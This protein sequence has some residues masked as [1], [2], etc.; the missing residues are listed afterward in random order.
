LIGRH[1]SH[2]TITA[3]LGEGGMAEVYRAVDT[4]LERTVAL[5]V[6][7]EE[8]AS[9]PQRLARFQ[10]EAKTVAALNHPNIV[11]IFSV[12]EA[13]G[14]HFLTMELVAGKA[15][16]ELL[17]K[18]GFSLDRFLALAT[19][20]ADAVASAHAQGIVHRDLKPANVMVTDEGDRVKVL[21]FGLAKPDTAADG[22]DASQ[23]LT[24]TQTQEGLILGTPHYMSPEQARG[25]PVDSRSDIFSLG[26]MFFELATGRRP[27]QGAASLE[28]L[29]SLLKDPPPRLLEIRPELPRHLGRV[30][31]RC[32]E[33]APADRYKTARDVYNELRA[34]HEETRTGSRIQPG[35]LAAKESRNALFGRDAERSRLNRMLDAATNGAGGLV[36]IG[37]EP[38]VGKTR[39]AVETLEDARERGLLVLTGHGYQDDTAPFITATEILE[40]LRRLV[41]PVDLRSMLG[42]DAPEVSR[43]LPELRQIYPDIP[44]TVDAPRGQEQR[45]LFKSVVEF[46]FRAA[47][48]N[49]LVML[50][51][52][53]NWADESSLL[54]LEHL[55][56]RVAELPILMIGTFRDAEAE[57]NVAFKRFL[58]RV[59][60]QRQAQR[61]R[62]ECLPL[63]SVTELVASIGGDEP[64]AELLTAIYDQTEG[65]PFFVEEVLHHLA[66]E[67]KLFDSEGRWRTDLRALDFRVPPGVKLVIGLRL[68]RL[69]KR[70]LAV[71]IAAAVAGRRFDLRMVEDLSGLDSDAFLNCLDEAEA[72]HLILPSND[73]TSYSFWH[74]LIRQTLIETLSGARRQR[75]HLRT[76][77]ALERLFSAEIE[78]HAVAL[79][80]HLSRAGALAPTD[81]I[82]RYSLMAGTQ[83]LEN[84]AWKEAST[85]FER[86]LDRVD[87]E[88]PELQTADLWYGLGR[89]QAASLDVHKSGIAVHSLAKAF[90][91]YVELGEHDRAVQAAAY[92][93]FVTAGHRKGI[94]ELLSRALAV[95][96]PGTLESGRLLQRFGWAKSQ[97]DGDL[98]TASHAFAKALKIA[99]EH[100]DDSLRLSTLTN[101]CFV[102]GLHLR[103]DRALESAQSSLELARRLDDPRGQMTV[104]TMR[105]FVQMLT[106]QL[107]CAKV[108]VEA[109]RAL[110]DKLADVSWQ[111]TIYF[112]KA[113]LDR[114]LGAL[115]PAREALEK[116]LDLWPR[117]VRLLGLRA[118]IEV[119]LG[120]LEDATTFLERMLEVMSD[121]TPGPTDD[122]AY[123][124]MTLAL[125][126]HMIGSRERLEAAERAGTMVVESPS[127]SPFLAQWANTG[128]A[129]SAIARGD[130][131]RAEKL[132]ESLSSLEGTFVSG[133]GCSIDRVLGL[134]AGVR[135][136]PAQAIDHFENAIETCR[137][138]T[139]RPELAWTLCESAELLGKDGDRGK[140][141]LDR[142]KESIALADELGLATL[143]ARASE[144]R[145]RIGN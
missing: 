77:E 22:G 94:S 87:P 80:R 102:N 138:A 116:G 95:V 30:I 125:I 133:S 4:K 74:E 82:V 11:T 3:K 56:R 43:L 67:T 65:N 50:L 66:E 57:M 38:G 137:R 59:V 25:E 134:L 5:K 26:A 120:E 123:P 51:D 83:A 70:T 96:P 1:L 112:A 144:L 36:L 69:D 62:L 23:L 9:D 88:A 73:G 121:S 132:Y 2:F 15:L 100:D 81:K 40:D 61:V 135:A 89:A 85:Y 126:D 101:L 64:P 21:D 114:Q 29:S 84:Y 131:R 46:L 52:D 60:G 34:L 76:A 35:S 97:E 13:D 58:A 79:C 7:P 107:R 39:L 106:G 55:V 91:L 8:M 145:R 78:N 129:F 71:L 86:G 111:T 98:E 141:A 54:L 105:A 63:E 28:L 136:Q 113:S 115:A 17:P 44:E 118:Q 53:L 140:E 41:S 19:P 68:E 18:G 27:F 32:L 127:V 99:A 92:P 45:L 108:S 130:Q 37:G 49:P 119:E 10:R 6:L 124:P 122:H 128:L 109:A 33:K 117:D 47:T 139:A 93:L 24:L 103:F 48:Q 12:E 31:G 142:L 75:L 143:E 104:L 42:N 16:N 110:A 14:I 90:D 72:T 20:I